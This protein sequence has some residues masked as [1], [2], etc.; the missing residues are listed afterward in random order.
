MNIQALMQQAKKMQKNMAKKQEE[1]NAKEFTLNN[2]GIEIKMTGE[3][4]VISIN[5]DNDLIDPEDKEMLF[6]LLQIT[7]NKLMEQIDAALSESMPQQA[8]GMPGLF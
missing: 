2:Q 1:F 5:I 6:D 8:A 7:I 3:K 4:K